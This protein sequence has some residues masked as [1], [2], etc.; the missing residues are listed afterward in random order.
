MR[1]VSIVGN[2]HPK[3]S[4]DVGPV[5]R[6]SWRSYGLRSTLTS[7]TMTKSYI[8]RWLTTDPELVA[9]QITPN[10]FGVVSTAWRRSGQF[11]PV[12]PPFRTVFQYILPSTCKVNDSTGT[13]SRG[14]RSI[15]WRGELVLFFLLVA[16]HNKLVFPQGT[17]STSSALPT[18][19]FYLSAL[20]C[21]LAKRVVCTWSS[22]S[23]QS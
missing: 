5:G 12:S 9:G 14:P 8:Q 17:E 15:F 4:N 19:L 18:S 22:F 13:C 6:L 1:I 10:L 21:S 7:W 16:E 20:C 2:S 11:N 3:K 23:R